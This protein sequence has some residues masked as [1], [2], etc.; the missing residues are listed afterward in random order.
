MM[1]AETVVPISEHQHRGQVVDSATH[2]AQ[3]VKRR[4][5]RPV[6]VLDDEHRGARRRG[7]LVRHRGE[8]EVRV[9]PGQR[10]GQRTVG[11][12]RGIAERSERTWRRQVL[13]GAGQNLHVSAVG[14]QECPDQ[15]GLADTGLPEHEHRGPMSRGSPLDARLERLQLDPPFEQVRHSQHRRTGGQI[16]PGAGILLPT[17]P[18][19]VVEPFGVG[20]RRAQDGQPAPMRR[21]RP[22]ITLNL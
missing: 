9:R 1:R 18:T 14:S 6:S 11:R 20:S 22:G 8:D 4:S 17:G 21:S 12:S 13:A 15:A 16:L 2:V 3:H 19:P 5:V 7:Q 10:L